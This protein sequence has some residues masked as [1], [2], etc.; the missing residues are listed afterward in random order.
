MCACMHACMCEH[1]RCTWKSRAYQEGGRPAFTD[2]GHAVQLQGTCVEVAWLLG[3]PIVHR[4]QPLQAVVE[5][6]PPG[7]TVSH[8]LYNGQHTMAIQVGNW[9]VSTLA[10]P[11]QPRQL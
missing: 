1:M 6:L 10:S 4:F 2:N 11:T 7:H 8:L 3:G 9:P 5:P